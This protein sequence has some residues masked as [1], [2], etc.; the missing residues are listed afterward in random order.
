[1]KRK[2]LTLNENDILNRPREPGVGAELATNELKVK[3]SSL[4]DFN[5]ELDKCEVRSMG[6]CSETASSVMS[7][8]DESETVD[9]LDELK[10]KFK[11][12][13]VRPIEG[14]EG[15]SSDGI[16]ESELRNTVDKLDHMMLMQECANKNVPNNI[17]PNSNAALETSGKNLVPQENKSSVVKDS[18]STHTC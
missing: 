10:L 2:G 11:E 8:Q 1:M 7:E 5:L 17:I 6:S 14:G 4:P 15:K 3:Y 18:I 16:W 12:L 9:D 13:A